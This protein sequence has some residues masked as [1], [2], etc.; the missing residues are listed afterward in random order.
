MAHVDAGLGAD[1]AQKLAVGVVTAG[2][3]H[4]HIRAQKAQIVGDIPAHAAGAHADKTGVGVLRDKRVPGSS[5]DI[6]IG[7]ADHDHIGT[8][9]GN[10]ILVHWE[11]TP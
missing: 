5:A 3:E 6:H 2:G 9:R 11:S 7:T 4:P 1:G 8:A 10:T